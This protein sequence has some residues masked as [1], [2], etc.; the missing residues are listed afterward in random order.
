MIPIPWE[1]L[2]EMIADWYAAG[3]TYKGNSFTNAD[4]IEWWV[5]CKDTMSLNPLTRAAVNR[6]IHHDCVLKRRKD[7]KSVINNEKLIYETHIQMM[8]DERKEYPKKYA[9]MKN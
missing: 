9:L 6:I 2:L 4:E 8:F 1:Y 7:I 5:I 3:R